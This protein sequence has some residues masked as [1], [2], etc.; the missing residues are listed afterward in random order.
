MLFLTCACRGDRYDALRACIGESL[1]LKLHSFRVFMVGCGAIGC[2]M[3]KNL[4]LLGVGLNR[5]SGEVG[6]CIWQ[7]SFFSLLTYLSNGKLVQFCI[8]SIPRFALLIQI[9][10][11]N[12][13]STGSFSSD[14]TTYRYLINLI[15]FSLFHSWITSHFFFAHFP[16]SVEA[17]EHYSS[18]RYI[19]N[20][21]RAP[22]R[23]S[24]E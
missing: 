2:E 1:C 9:W 18:S 17:K 11:R 19:R 8:F 12:P 15:V 7:D 20:K 6:I 24:S 4:A 23:C 21:P 22:N 10:L 14:H 13:T 5:C 16:P 3:L